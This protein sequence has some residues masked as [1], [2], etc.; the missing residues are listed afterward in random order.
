[1]LEPPERA[2]TFALTRPIEFKRSMF[3]LVRHGQTPLGAENRWQGCKQDV[4]LT[5]LGCAEVAAL[6]PFLPNVHIFSS[7]LKRTIQTST[8]I[9]EALNVP[10]YTYEEL[11][12]V[13]IG[14]WGGRT[15][16]ETDGMMPTEV[17]FK[18]RNHMLIDFPEGETV[19]SII[20]RTQ[21]FVD[22]VKPPAIIVGHQLPLQVLIC[23]LTGID[24]NFARKLHI[25]EAALSIVRHTELEVLNFK[26][27]R[28]E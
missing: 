26:N 20:A 23:L 28:I 2:T 16:E 1:M 18:Q 4:E 13:D 11:K 10:F 9:S 22:Q 12:D 21:H 19:T 7:P 25:D 17:K 8:I 24:L 5:P 27:R 14:L 15:A 3:F 6:V